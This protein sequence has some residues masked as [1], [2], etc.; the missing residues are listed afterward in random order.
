VVDVEGTDTEEN[1]AGGRGEVGRPRRHLAG[2]QGVNAVDR[3][4]EMDSVAIGCLS[5]GIALMLGQT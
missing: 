2:I 1:F 3:A 4:Q 5:V